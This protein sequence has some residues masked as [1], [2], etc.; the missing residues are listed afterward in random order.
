MPQSTLA[1][2]ARRLSVLP[3]AR[4]FLA[5]AVNVLRDDGGGGFR[6]VGHRPEK[7][8][9]DPPDSGKN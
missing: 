8:G 7:A 4:I 2:S 9:G 3:L 1:D 6:P 5:F